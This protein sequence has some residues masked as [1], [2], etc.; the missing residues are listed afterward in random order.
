MMGIK[1]GRLAISQ[2][3]DQYQAGWQTAL[4]QIYIAYMEMAERYCHIRCNFSFEISYC[5]WLSGIFA[6]K[7]FYN[8]GSEKFGQVPSQKYL[9][10]LIL[11]MKLL[12]EALFWLRERIASDTCVRLLPLKVLDDS[13]IYGT[14][15]HRVLWPWLGEAVLG[16]TLHYLTA[17]T[18]WAPSDTCDHKIYILGLG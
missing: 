2:Y 13:V 9:T 7:F 16:D 8:Q 14:P 18:R 12:T 5:I 11:K 6:F 1:A 10:H 15:V 3:F 4:S 17:V